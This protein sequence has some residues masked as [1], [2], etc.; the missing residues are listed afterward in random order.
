MKLAGRATDMAILTVAFI[1]KDSLIAD[2]T[3]HIAHG[4]LLEVTYCR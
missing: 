3:R 4:D 1:A 2:R